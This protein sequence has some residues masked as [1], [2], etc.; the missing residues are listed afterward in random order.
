MRREN[1]PPAGFQILPNKFS[2]GAKGSEEAF[3]VLTLSKSWPSPTKTLPPRSGKGKRF[4]EP[5]PD[6]PPSREGSGVEKRLP[7]LPRSPLP[8]QVTLLSDGIFYSPSL[9]RKLGSPPSPKAD[10]GVSS[11]ERSRTPFP[12]DHLDE[13]E[14]WGEDRETSRLPSTGHVPP[15]PR[16]TPPSP[17]RPPADM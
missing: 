15:S 16:H 5:L 3:E 14:D 2:I 6:A 12:R 8:S 17:M 4:L 11:A 1:F 9:Q 13:N 7:P 10:S